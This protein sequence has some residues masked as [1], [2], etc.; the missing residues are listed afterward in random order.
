MCSSAITPDYTMPVTVSTFDAGA[1]R[2]LRLSAQL[3]YQ[4]EVGERHLAP[5]GFDYATLYDRGMVF[6]LTRTRSVIHRA[7]LLGESLQLTTWHRDSRGAQLFRC[8]VFQDQAGRPL[9]ESV[10]AFALVDPVSHTLL[11]HGAFDS[12]GIAAQPDRRGGCPD[13]D[14]L[15]LPLEL[16][17]AGQRPVYWSDTDYNGHMNNTVYADV[18]CDHLPGGMAGRR[19]TGFT[20]A[21]RTE[22]RAGET[23]TIAA[24]DENGTV[25]LR[26][27]DVDRCFFEAC[28]TY[29]PEDG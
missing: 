14:R 19:L 2:R 17:V 16:P 26:G 5:G 21:Y 8:Y 15:K 4:Q 6:V 28:I 10:T 11:R 3:R 20:I 22:V 12:F 23:M 27:G 18:L 29:E 7:P 24:A 9:I 1:D 13:P 25:S